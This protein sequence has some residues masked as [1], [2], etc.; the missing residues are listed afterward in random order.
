M[1]LSGSGWAARLEGAGGKPADA[2]RGRQAGDSVSKFGGNE[3]PDR[4]RQRERDLGAG[5][6][7]A[8]LLVQD[9]L[10][11]LA[12]L[13]AGLLAQLFL[14]VV[15]GRVG[16]AERQLLRNEQQQRQ[17]YV[18]Q[19]TRHSAIVHNKKAGAKAGFRF[20]Y[21]SA[22]VTRTETDAQ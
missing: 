5:G 1:A 6:A 18:D 8:A 14:D 20:H 7:L 17:E 21:K 10:G 19:A 16:M 11:R 4:G 13:A 3:L 12:F 2:G 15:P 22:S 9:R